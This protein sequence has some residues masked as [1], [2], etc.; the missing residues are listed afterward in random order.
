MVALRE[1][2]LPNCDRR[3][4][5]RMFLI[6]NVLRLTQGVLFLVVAGLIIIE[7]SDVIDLFKDFAALSLISVVDNAAFAI[8]E[9]GFLGKELE[10]DTKKVNQ[11][12]INT[13]YKRRVTMVVFFFFFLLVVGLSYFDYL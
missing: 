6:S 3:S 13:S 7:S 9:T 5:K 2:L 10:R 8:S 11:L 12:K 4:A 1:A